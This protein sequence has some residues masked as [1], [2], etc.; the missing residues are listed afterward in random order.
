MRPVSA[1]SWWMAWSIRRAISCAP[2]GRELTIRYY[3]KSRLSSPRMVR[4][5]KEVNA[6]PRAGSKQ[7]IAPSSPRLATWTRS[8][9][10]SLALCLRRSG[11]RWCCPTL[12]SA[13]IFS[14]T[15]Q[16]GETRSAGVVVR[17][18]SGPDGG[19]RE[20]GAS[21]AM[22]GLPAREERGCRRRPRGLRGG[23]VGTSRG[24]RCGRETMLKGVAQLMRTRF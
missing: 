10:G 1:V 19:R 11:G 14:S 16:P 21:P 18:S 7:S 6:A 2:R 24:S 20:E 5:A 22:A 8:S 15:I 9:I 4:T 17:S 13:V 23:R 12:M 3:G